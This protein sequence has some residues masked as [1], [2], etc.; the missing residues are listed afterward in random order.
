MGEVRYGI[1]QLGD[2]TA[3][4]LAAC[5]LPQEDARLAAEILMRT[6][7][8]GIR[9]H[10]LSRLYSYAGKI[11][12]GEVNPRPLLGHTVREGVLHCDGDGG[13]GQVIGPKVIDLALDMAREAAFVPCFL[14]D[15]GHLGGLGVLALRAAEAGMVAFIVQASAPSMALPGA[16][17]KAIGNSPLAFAFPRRGADPFVFD[18]ATSQTSRGNVLLAARSD[19]RIPEGWAIDREGRPTT[20]AKEALEGSMLPVGD[21]KGIGLSMMIE[22]LSSSLTGTH[23]PAM[24]EPDGSS[25]SA[26]MHVGC[27]F[28]VANPDRLIGRDGFDAHIAGWIDHYLSASA[29]DSR[30]PGDRANLCERDCRDHG[31]AIPALI[32]E[33][34]RR[35]G[36]ELRI[37]FAPAETGAS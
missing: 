7:A 19:G 33:E 20:N 23:A 37:P 32:F 6:E 9:T 22:C 13:L 8:R 12:R 16:R 4:I 14:K 30:I 35:L 11:Q 36:T 31:I 28:F 2:W 1:E 3:Q 10:G 34:L 26:S 17:G 27:F 29:S 5:G 18:M 21:H 24:I 25:G 15:C